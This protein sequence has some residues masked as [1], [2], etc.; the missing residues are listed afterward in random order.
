ML[1]FRVQGDAAVCLAGLKDADELPDLAAR[2]KRREVLIAKFADRLPELHGPELDAL[3]VVLWAQLVKRQRKCRLPD[4][5]WLSTVGMADAL[6]R[7]V[8]HANDLEDSTP[9][10]EEEEEGE[11]EERDE[12][13]GTPAGG[14]CVCS[15]RRRDPDLDRSEW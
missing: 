7:E 12:P 9:A 3:A 10:E 1:P 13:P 8:I 14:L 2:T 4:Q 6:A 11:Y 15:S 5:P